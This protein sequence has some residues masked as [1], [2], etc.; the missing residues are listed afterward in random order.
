MSFY[1]VNVDNVLLCTRR[2]KKTR[3]NNKKIFPEGV[4]R[5]GD[6]L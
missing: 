5:E 4:V 1:I 3:H 2:G 6:D